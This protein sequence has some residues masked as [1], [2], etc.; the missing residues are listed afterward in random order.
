LI[1]AVINARVTALYDKP[2][3]LAEYTAK[4]TEK[5]RDLARSHWLTLKKVRN[6][7]NNEIG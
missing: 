4:L 5:Q 3:S 6:V 1:Q 7:K 2:E